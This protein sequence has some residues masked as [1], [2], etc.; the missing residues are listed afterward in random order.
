MES[1]NS[2]SDIQALNAD[3]SHN[4]KPDSLNKPGIVKII[5]HKPD[6]LA[7]IADTSHSKKSDSVNKSGIVKV[8]PQKIAINFS[9]KR[10][11]TI[12]QVKDRNKFFR[13]LG[14][15]NSS[16]SGQ[17]PNFLSAE[18]ALD[19][20]SFYLS[21]PLVREYCGKIAYLGGLCTSQRCKTIQD[22]LKPKQP[23]SPSVD[24]VLAIQIKTD[25][26]EIY[27]EAILV[28]RD[29]RYFWA[30]GSKRWK[31]IYFW[32]LFGIF[33]GILR[34][35]SASKEAGAYSMGR[36]NR[37]WPWYITEIIIGPFV[38]ISVFFI[39]GKATASLIEG[40]TESEIKTSIYLTMGLAFVL[41]FYIR[42]TI[43]LLLT[44]ANYL[45]FKS[46]SSSSSGK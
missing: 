44:F 14:A 7:L 33:A 22:T 39:A 29:D 38:V 30:V 20:I 18:T 43:E 17:K 2:L 36:L 4:I 45:K 5:T 9:K 42:R 46:P 27:K 40:I 12:D 21:D 13:L 1:R 16:L 10:K 8:I 26:T 15:A 25:L 32:A 35:I 28:E 31:E 11:E 24:L 34:W 6:T 3:T 19:S 37:E 41:G 23:D